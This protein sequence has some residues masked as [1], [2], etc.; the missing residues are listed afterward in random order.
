VN[1]PTLV[2]VTV[3]SRFRASLIDQGLE[4]IGQVEETVQE[5]E[6]FGRRVKVVDQALVGI[7]RE[8]EVA[9]VSLIDRI[10]LET[11]IDRS[12]AEIARTSIGRS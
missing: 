11:A 7:D 1:D 4:E 12:S 8:K 6:A 5:L 2:M 9:L 10:V 3:L